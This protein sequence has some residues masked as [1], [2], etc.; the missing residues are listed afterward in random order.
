MPKRQTKTEQT[1]V[2]FNPL[3]LMRLDVHADTVQRTRTY[4]I[5]RAVEEYLDRHDK[6]AKPA[7]AK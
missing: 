3:L 6:P 1:S 4:L 5:E 7:P 2:R